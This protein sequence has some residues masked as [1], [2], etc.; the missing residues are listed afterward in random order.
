MRKL[1]DSYY[2][3]K[4]G[5]LYLK[6]YKGD[7]RDVEFNESEYNAY[8]FYF[9]EITNLRQW[10]E[11]P[12]STDKLNVFAEVTSL[13]SRLSKKGFDNLKIVERKVYEE[14]ETVEVEVVSHGDGLIQ[15]VRE[16][17]E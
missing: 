4:V 2:M 9:D 15:I 8:K 3:I 13:L 12:S 16:V 10:D 14:Q 7:I 6:S 1:V 5:S 11:P 17:K